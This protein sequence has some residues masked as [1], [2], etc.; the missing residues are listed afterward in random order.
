[1]VSLSL[2]RLALPVIEYYEYY[3][4]HHVTRCRFIT[5]HGMLKPAL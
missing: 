5:E 2:A 3:Y 1:M 4:K